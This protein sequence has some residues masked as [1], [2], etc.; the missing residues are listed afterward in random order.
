MRMAE[1]KTIPD[2]R[3][4]HL[5]YRKTYLEHFPDEMF[6]IDEKTITFSPPPIY[7]FNA[8]NPEFP[9]NISS[10]DMGHPTDPRKYHIIYR[11]VYLEHFPDELFDIDE[12]TV[13]FQHPELN[14]ENTYDPEFPYMAPK[15]TRRHC[16]QT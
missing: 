7:M 14:Q 4:Y 2:P 9:M 11:Q 3:K 13:K 10:C 12:K 6:D 8:Y 5:A 15:H 1:P 16:G